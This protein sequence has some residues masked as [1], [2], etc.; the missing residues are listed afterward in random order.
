MVVVIV[1]LIQHRENGQSITVEISR[2]RKPISISYRFL[3]IKYFI[4]RNHLVNLSIRE[5]S[6]VLQQRSYFNGTITV[7]V[8]VKLTDLR[9][10]YYYY[11]WGGKFTATQWVYCIPFRVYNSPISL[12]SW[13]KSIIFVG[14]SVTISSGWRVW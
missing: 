10:Y 1:V 6:T 11:V 2:Y 5:A 8:A 3:N 12:I 13:M 14:L 7:K 4:V 9:Y